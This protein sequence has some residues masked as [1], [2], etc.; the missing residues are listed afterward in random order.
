MSSFYQKWQPETLSEVAGH[1]SAKHKL[2]TLERTI[3]LQGQVFWITGQSGTGKN[4][5]AS[6]L[7]KQVS[8]EYSCRCEVDAQDVSLD[9][10]REW[11]LKA[12]RG[13]L[14][15]GFS[16]TVNE[17]HGLS[18]R[19][20]SRLQTLLEDR[21]VQANSTWFFTT[22]FR[23]E[24]KLFDS[25]MDACPFLS[26]AIPVKLELDADTVQAMAERLQAI[27]VAESVDGRPLEAYVD[28]LLECDCNMRL[29]LQRIACGEMLE[30]SHAVA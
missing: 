13:S 19:A 15:G 14:F 11:E 4:T 2:Q 12:S 30:D 18:S 21:D 3:G 16:F 8:P 26:R 1:A 10:L 5:I 28:F 25:R 29:A 24:A 27:A 9:L 7:A 6:V 23:G 22:T 17:A 20:V